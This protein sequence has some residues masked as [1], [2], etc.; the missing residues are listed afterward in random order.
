MSPDLSLVIPALNEGA[1]L[2][3]TVESALATA[4]AATE[5]IVIDDGSSDGCADF[6]R[7]GHWPVRLLEPKAAGSRLGASAARNRG[8]RVAH[9]SVLV[10]LDAHVELPPGWAERLQQ[11]LRNPSVGAAAPAIS[12]LGAPA[13]KGFGLRWRDPALGIEWL[14]ARTS[15]PYAAPLLPGACFALRRE[16]FRASGGFDEG[17]IRWGCEDAELS[18]RLWSAGYELCLVPDVEVA[19][20]FRTQ[21]P[22]EIDHAD[23]VH[24]TLRV[25]WLHFDERRLA[26]VV[27]ALK[28]MRAFNASVARL[29]AGDAGHRRT[30]LRV[31]RARSD[32]QYFATFGDII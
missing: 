7:Q 16:V 18:L 5:I 28:P 11:V 21:H 10:F 31:R 32:D 3:R 23:I 26:H 2:R 1:H 15:T 6:L 24:N 9:G 13:N 14:P 30:R 27:D 20:L 17:L 29:A 25:A 19:H 22:Y 4:P 12:V 8:G